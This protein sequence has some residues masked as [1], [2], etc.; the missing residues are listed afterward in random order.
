MSDSGKNRF[1]P[2]KKKKKKDDIGNVK[3]IDSYGGM[4]EPSGGFWSSE[5]RAY[6]DLLTIK[7]LFQSE[8]WVFLAT[9]AI[10]HPIS[11]LPLKV[12]KKIKEQDEIIY[13]PNMG[14][15]INKII[16]DPNEFSTTCELLYGLAADYVLAGNSYAWRGEGGGLYHIPAENILY[17]FGTN[18]VPDGYY[19]IS[20]FEDAMPVPQFQVELD[21]IGHTKRPNPSSSLYG[22]TPFAPAKRSILFNRYSQEYLNNFYLKG[23]TPQMLLELQK[24]AQDKSLNRLQATFEQGFTGRRNQRRTMI[25]PKGVTAKTI[26]NKI[27]DQN[28]I[29]LIEANAD[30]ILSVLKIPKHIVGRQEK[31]SLASEEMKSAMRYFWQTTITDTARAIEQTLTKL[32]KTYLGEDHVL[33]FDFDNVSELQHDV[34]K[35]A[36]LSNKMLGFMTFNEVRENYWNLPP[37][38]G[39]DVI[40]SLQQQQMIKDR[41]DFDLPSEILGKKKKFRRP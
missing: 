13:K 5:N 6:L 27:A 22:L 28:I 7:S 35:K 25:L 20:D 17:R 40:L 16:A 36:E 39:G 37:V 9:D 24:D 1:Y 30:R 23:A 8:D 2:T 12:Y 33:S 4:S 14:H 10:A 26:E 34:E 41:V 11:T 31:G 19:I 21:E 32:F 18:N 38:E 15:S 3:Y 29:E